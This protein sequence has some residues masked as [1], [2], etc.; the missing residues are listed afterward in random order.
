MIENIHLKKKVIVS[1]IIMESDKPYQLME[2]FEISM[3]S[4][5]AI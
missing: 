2:G 1:W 4:A 3:T 5:F